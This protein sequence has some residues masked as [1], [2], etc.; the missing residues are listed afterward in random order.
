MPHCKKTV[1][2]DKHR[3]KSQQHILAHL[4]LPRHTKP[5]L[6]KT[7]RAKIFQPHQHS[8][9]NYS[10]VFYTEIRDIK[11]E[12]TTFATDYLNYE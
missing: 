6:R 5:T 10:I 2:T 11:N 3:Q 8:E 9:D 4:F 1:Q 7:K 12:M